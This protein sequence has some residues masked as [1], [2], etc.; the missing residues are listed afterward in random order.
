MGDF[1]LPSSRC[2]AYATHVPPYRVS[3]AQAFFQACHSIARWYFRGR[4][5]YQWVMMVVGAQDFQ[6]YSTMYDQVLKIWTPLPG[7]VMV[8]SSLAF[9]RYS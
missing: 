8:D 5:R 3:K 1:Q 4:Q 7:H 9:A 6:G 2:T